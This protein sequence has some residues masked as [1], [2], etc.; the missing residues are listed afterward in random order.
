MNTLI[1]LAVFLVFAAVTAVLTAVAKKES[2]RQKLLAAAIG[3][4]STL[5]YAAVWAVIAFFS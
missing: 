4:L 2:T 1:A 3:W 5:A